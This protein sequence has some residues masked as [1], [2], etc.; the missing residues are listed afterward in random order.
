MNLKDLIQKIKRANLSIH[1]YI[2]VTAIKEKWD[3]HDTVKTMYFASDSIVPQ[4]IEALEQELEMTGYM[5]NGKPTELI[6]KVLYKGDM[7][8]MLDKIWKAY[9]SYTPNGRLLKQ[10]KK[11]VLDKLKSIIAKD[12]DKAQAILNGIE[13]YI[14][15]KKKTNS[16]DYI[17]MFETFVNQKGWEDEIP[18]D[19]PERKIKLL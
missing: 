13:R 15:H 14:K 12:Y 10:N 19:Q 7:S 2:Y 1:G 6:K 3:I 11:R 16:E 18:E 4:L 9:P 8:E 5:E 17:R